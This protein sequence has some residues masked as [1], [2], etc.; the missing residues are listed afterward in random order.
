MDFLIAG[1]SKE[2]ARGVDRSTRKNRFEAQ[3]VCLRKY[4]IF[5]QS[6]LLSSGALPLLL[7]ERR[8][9]ETLLLPF[10]E[11][12]HRSL[13]CSAS[14]SRKICVSYISS[15]ASRAS[16]ASCHDYAPCMDIKNDTFATAPLPFTKRSFS[17]AGST[18]GLCRVIRTFQFCTR[19]CKCTNI[20]QIFITFFKIQI[21]SR[22][23]NFFECVV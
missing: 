13:A 10:N 17:G 7:M 14:G 1:T 18:G 9:P 19:N 23:V 12:V 8:L 3:N 11:V 20:G 15:R 6:F 4:T 22:I 16:L 2:T 21:S 5:R